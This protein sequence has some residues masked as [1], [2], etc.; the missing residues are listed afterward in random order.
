MGGEGRSVRVE[1]ACAP[2]LFPCVPDDTHTPNLP[3]TCTLSFGAGC[4]GNHRHAPSRSSLDRA[5]NCDTVGIGS[6]SP[7]CS[8]CGSTNTQPGGRLM[9]KQTKKRQGNKSMSQKDEKYSPTR[10]AFFCWI[11]RLLMIV[12]SERSITFIPRLSGP[13]SSTCVG[14]GEIKWV[15]GEGFF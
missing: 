3:R 4:Y 10:T 2:L 15:G 1:G 14:V 9:G 11:T 13:F 5:G 6:E 7:T 8:H 12:W